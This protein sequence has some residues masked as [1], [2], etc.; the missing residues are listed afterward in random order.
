MRV[1]NFIEAEQV[2]GAGFNETAARM[3]EAA[4]NALINAGLITAATGAGA[5]IGGLLG[6]GGGLAFSSDPMS[7]ALTGSLAGGAVGFLSSLN[8]LGVG[9]HFVVHI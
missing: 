2:S 8:D 4:E 5:G 3:R 1:M 9:L 6:Y 7:V